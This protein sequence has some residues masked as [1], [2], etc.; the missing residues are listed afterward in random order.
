MEK[1][2]ITPKNKTSL[3]FLKRPFSDLESIRNVE[4]VHDEEIKD[5]SLL[6]K[7]KQNLKTGLITHRYVIN[8]LDKIISK[9]K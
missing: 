8:T 2:L 3:T 1:L 9:A 5:Y 7:M 6:A 4:V